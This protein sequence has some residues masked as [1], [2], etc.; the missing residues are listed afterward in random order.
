M[1]LD[2][3]FS[4]LKKG[5][6]KLHYSA[7]RRTLTIKESLCRVYFTLGAVNANG[8]AFYEGDAVSFVLDPKVV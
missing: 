4:E 2:T 8:N 3:L 6:K 1:K 7:K 5:R